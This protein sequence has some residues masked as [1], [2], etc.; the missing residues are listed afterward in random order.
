MCS[1]SIEAQGLVGSQRVRRL[2]YPDFVLK[3]VL[4]SR[5]GDLMGI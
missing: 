4:L 1:T 3:T 5:L 2:F